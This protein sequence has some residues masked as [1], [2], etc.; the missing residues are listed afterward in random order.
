M[1]GL[2]QFDFDLPQGQI[3]LYPAAERTG[4]RLLALDET[5][6]TEELKFARIARLL[7][8][9]DLLVC[10]D[11]KVIPA[12]LIGAK[13]TGGRV[14]ILVERI[15]GSTRMLA[16]MRARKSLRIGDRVVIAD[17]VELVVAGRDGEFF[18]VDVECSISADS[19]IARY[20][21]VPLPPYI[22]RPA[23]ALDTQRY[24]NVYARH[25]GSVAAPTAGLHFSN[26]LMTQL[27]IAGIEFEY[28]TLH[29]GA[30]TFAPIRDGQVDGHRLHRERCAISE[31]ACERINE[32]KR[33]G[34]RV[35]AVGTTSVRTLETAAVAGMLKPYS[36]ETQLFIKPGFE[37]QIADAIITNFH[38][39]RSTLLMLVCAFAGTARVL[40]AY[41]YAVGSG[42]RFYSYGDAMFAVRQP[43]D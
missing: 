22:D 30:G 15:V 41:R 9:G 6:A 40:K 31:S 29:V 26:E 33:A 10:N 16:Q 1:P 11:S 4:S 23:E 43:H 37:F 13:P 3:A 8:P 35:I 21:A 32:A 12:R 17:Q 24:Q 20:G 36:A 39:P 34:R 2:A 25:D 19:L 7:R 42:F 28:L 27:E 18:L 14:E 38:L 5:G